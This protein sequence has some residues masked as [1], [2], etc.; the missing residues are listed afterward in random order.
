MTDQ[1]LRSLQSLNIESELLAA[2]LIEAPKPVTDPAK[3]LQT[4]SAPQTN[5]LTPVKFLKG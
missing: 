4:I 2:G 1:F 3:P 5:Q